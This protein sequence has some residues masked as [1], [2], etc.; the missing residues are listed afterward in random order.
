MVY[1]AIHRQIS[2]FEYL[3]EHGAIIP[4]N[5]ADDDGSV[6]GMLEI[7][8]T[9]ITQAGILARDH[10]IPLVALRAIHEYLFGYNWCM[11]YGVLGE[12]L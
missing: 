8:Q 6:I 7:R 3:C 4:D 2:A 11:V 12:M 1:A 10:Q 5:Y 9:W